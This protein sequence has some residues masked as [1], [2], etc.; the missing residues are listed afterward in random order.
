MLYCGRDFV[1]IA[2]VTSQIGK[3]ELLKCLPFTGSISSEALQPES[4]P[5]LLEAYEQSFPFTCYPSTKENGV[6][7]KAEVS[8]S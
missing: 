4:E 5:E 3:Q 1:H 2:L 6:D 8:K 7:R